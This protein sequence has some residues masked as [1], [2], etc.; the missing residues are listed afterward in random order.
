VL[1]NDSGF[2]EPI[3]NTVSL[4]QIKKH[5]KVSLQDYFLRE[6]GQSNSEVTLSL[7]PYPLYDAGIPHRTAELCA[8]LRRLLHRLI[9]SPGVQCSAV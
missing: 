5:S 9:F 7:N 6:F 8:E 2:I 1:S 4:H 3:L